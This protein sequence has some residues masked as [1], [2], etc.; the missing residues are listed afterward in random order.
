MEKSMSWRLARGLEHL[1]AQVNAKWPNRSKNSDGSVGDTS[2]SARVSDHNPDGSGVVHAIDITHDPKGGF[3][4]YAF[5]DMLLA[6]QDRRLKY[7]ISNRRIGSGPTGPAP[8]VWRK[9]TGSNP[10]D[11]HCHISIVSGSLADDVSDWDIG[12]A[13]GPAQMPPSTYEPPP[14]TLRE[15]SNGETVKRLQS[16]LNAKG[17]ALKVDGDF[18]PATKAALKKFQADRGLFQDGI[19]GPQSWKALK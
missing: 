1:R 19:C 9:Y 2:H 11:H 3:D 15:G 18:G 5:A 8:G 10:H 17:A 6:K 16:A 14:P 13:A 7:V 12:M 4:S